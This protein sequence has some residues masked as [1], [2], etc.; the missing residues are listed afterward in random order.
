VDPKPHEIDAT[1]WPDEYRPVLEYLPDDQPSRRPRQP[2]A[3]FGGLIAGLVISLFLLACAYAGFSGFMHASNNALAWFGIVGA[4]GCLASVGVGISLWASDARRCY[5]GRFLTIA[6]CFLTSF[7]CV[8][9]IC[10]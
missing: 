8:L 2:P 3:G 7:F 5:S 6:A 10:R 9:L 1:E 4:V